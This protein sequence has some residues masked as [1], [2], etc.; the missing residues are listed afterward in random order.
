MWK[1]IKSSGIL[2]TFS[3]SSS[4][5]FLTDVT[6]LF[7]G[8]A[9]T[10]EAPNTVGLLRSGRPCGVWDSLLCGVFSTERNRTPGVGARAGVAPFCN[11]VLGGRFLSKSSG[12]SGPQKRTLFFFLTVESFSAEHTVTLT[13][14]FVDFTECKASLLL[15]LTKIT[16]R[17]HETSDDE[18]YTVC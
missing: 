4:L 10:G 15:T 14:I 12:E 17:K 18:S 13:N 5:C 16:S 2:S 11:G 7:R 9:K 8:T 1:V 6:L 3:S